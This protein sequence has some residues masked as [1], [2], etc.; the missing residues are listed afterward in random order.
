MIQILSREVSDKIAAGEVVD[1]PLSIVKELVENALDAGADS[2]VVEIRNG[3]KTY[4]RVSDNGEGMRPEEAPLAF[5]RHA[6][7]KIRRAED[8]ERIQTLGFRGEALSSIAAVSRVEMVTRRASEKAGTLLRV[9][10]GQL[11][12]Q[13]SAGCPE[14]TTLVV[15]DLFYNT[16]ARLKFMKSDGAETAV[17]TEFMSRIALAYHQCR[18]RFIN[19]GNVLFSTPGDGDRF[20]NILTIYD[21]AVQDQLLPVNVQDAGYQ[22]SGYISKPSFT[23]ASRKHQIY[24]VNG[25]SIVSRVLDKAVDEAYREKMF[26]GRFPLAFLFLE[27]DPEKLD[28]NIHPNKKEIRFEEEQ[29]VCAFVARAV[30]QAL[31]TL[32]A[33]PGIPAGRPRPKVSDGEQVDIK[34]ILSNIREAEAQ[35]AA[36]RV[37]E[38]EELFHDGTAEPAANREPGDHP[39][40]D[41]STVFAVDTAG[42]EG[43]EPSDAPVPPVARGAEGEEIIPLGAV[44][45]SYLLASDGQHFYMIDQHAAHERITYERLIRRKNSEPIA[46]QQLLTPMILGLSYGERV[47]M[48]DWTRFL[49]EL[50]YEAEEFGPRD[51]R[52]TGVP[53]FLSL[54][55][56][57]D[58]LHL[59]V[60]NAHENADL[61]NPAMRERLVARACKSSVKAGDALRPEEMKRL[62]LDLFRCENPYSCP[63]GRPTLIRMS[64][65]EIERMFKRV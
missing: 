47:Q 3:G 8:L 4:I 17:I 26:E 54:Q 65:Q 11:L 5:L 15:E 22:L 20:R 13:R 58:F 56:A 55:E 35:E 49:V 30:R 1:R 12:D 61:A 48:E 19:N 44:F 16:P 63:H 2:L 27:A 51:L 62:I 43:N 39:D 64:K 50:G 36:L 9:A 32:N 33:A 24:F 59:L 45:S 37:R 18:I 28:V 57:R 60:E 6:T 29:Q 46:V 31:D 7:S 34:K 52:V 41:P 53:G 23:K 25:R 42:P 40:G 10:G 21:K 14:G 38:R